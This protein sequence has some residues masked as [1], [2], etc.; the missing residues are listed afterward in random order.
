MGDS[1]VSD[2]SNRPASAC[3]TPNQPLP[4]IQKTCVEEIDAFSQ[5]LKGHIE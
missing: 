4:E 3:I 1:G 2:E 5:R